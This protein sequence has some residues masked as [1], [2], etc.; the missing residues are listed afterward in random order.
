MKKSLLTDEE[1]H[2]IALAVDAAPELTAEQVSELRRLLRPAEMLRL[3]PVPDEVLHPALD[4][5]PG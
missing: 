3:R 2:L 5:N 4:P 1:H